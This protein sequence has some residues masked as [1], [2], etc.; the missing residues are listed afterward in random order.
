MVCSTAPDGDVIGVKEAFGGSYQMLIPYYSQVCDAS[1]GDVVW[2]EYDYN[3]MSTAKAKS[4]ASMFGGNFWTNIVTKTASAIWA[5]I[6]SQVFSEVYPIGSVY[7][8]ISPTSPANL[9]GGTWASFGLGRTLVGV[10]GVT[11]TSPEEVGGENSVYLTIDTM[12]N[13]YHSPSVSVSG[14]SHSHGYSTLNYSVVNRDTGSYGTGAIQGT[15]SRSTDSA[16]ANVSVSVTIGNTGNSQAHENRMPYITCYMWK[17][18][19]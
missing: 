2:V 18:I 5:A 19:A 9:F 6:K 17:R 1:V 8:S 3:N 12:P 15:S 13:H 16:N 4:I 14:G 7:C 11:Y 10:D